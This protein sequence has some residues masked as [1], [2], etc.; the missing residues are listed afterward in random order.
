MPVAQKRWWL[1]TGSELASQVVSICDILARESE[2][3]RLRYRRALTLYEGRAVDLDA[4]AFFTHD[5][6]GLAPLYNLVRSACDTAQAD[7]AARQKPKPQF[8]TTGAD[9]KARRRAKKLDKFVEAQ[10]NERQGCYA[11]AWQLALTC[12]LDSVKL[13]DGFA[14]VWA[15]MDH[16]KVRVER[17]YPWELF[18]DLR[19]ARY[20]D[21]QNLFHVYDIE[22]D[23]AIEAFCNVEGDPEGNERRQQ[24]L[25]SARASRPDSLRVVETV[26]LREAW[27]LPFSDEKPGKHVICVDGAV[28][29]E[30]DW[31]RPQFPFVRWVWDAES[32]GYWSTGLAEEGETQQLQVNDTAEK[33]SRRIAICSTKRT[34]YNAAAVKREHLESGGEE[35]VLISC[36]DM[37]QVPME[38]PVAPASQAEFEWLADNIRQFYE[39]RG[40][41]QMTANSQKPAGVTA[42]VAMQTLNDIQTV[43]FLPKARGYETSFV[44]MGHL[45]VQAARDIADEHG[46]YLVKW[47]G[48]RFINELDWTDVSLDEDMYSIRVAAVSQYSRDPAAILEMA[49]ELRS[50]GDI[51]RA[52]YL[53]MVGLPDLE[54]MLTEQTSERE[55]IE[56]LMGRYLDA[57]DQAELDKLGGYEAPEPLISDKPSAMALCVS[58]YWEAKRDRA[59]EFCLSSVRRFISQLDK[60][61]APPPVLQQP[62]APPMM[63]P[64]AAPP[65]LAPVPVAA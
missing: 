61:M 19:E 21:P 15:D 44:T 8:L 16:K 51:S 5:K 6:A 46:G 64:N 13:G 58:T 27:R 30:E 22:R 29:S 43:R 52:T 17:V 20:G 1:L 4:D 10:L 41:S 23:L 49:Q 31:T 25:E 45:M 57:T 28:L 35:E 12:F 47:P 63:A 56:E 38:A 65:G 60:L 54:A 40:I 9:W 62:A 3:R 55:F 36:L 24:A 50:T 37:A 39:I 32:V 53:D 34:Y 18:V 42:A 2:G 14:K 33:L 26:K 48:K 59:P 11:D 7:I